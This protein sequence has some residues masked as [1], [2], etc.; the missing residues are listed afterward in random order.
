MAVTT[1]PH[2]EFAPVIGL[3]GGVGSGKSSL[4]RSLETR[5][6]IVVINGDKVGHQVL[7]V[8]SV[9]HDIR[10]K[11]GESVLTSQGE[12][13]R[14]ALGRLVFGA[15]S[16]KQKARESLEAIV[17]P[18]IRDRFRELINSARE[19]TATRVVILD[20]AVL[21]ESGWRPLCDLV[22]FV[23]V[24]VDERLSRIK[25]RGWDTRVFEFREASQWSIEKKRDAADYIIDNSADLEQTRGRVQEIINVLQS[26]A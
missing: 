14:T 19:S 6:D 5:D 7:T 21:L 3:V 9:I 18:K 20:A 26:K 16:D 10:H 2:N 22:V 24:P 11:F 8:P 12:I 23:D 1:N 4:A 25:A 15:D 13:D 17:H